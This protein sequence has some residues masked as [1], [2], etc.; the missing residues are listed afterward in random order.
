MAPKYVYP[1]EHA[2]D[3]AHAKETVQ[4]VHTPVAQHT[5]H[6]MLHNSNNFI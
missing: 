1:V 2:T 3:L 4:V 5:L 6:Y